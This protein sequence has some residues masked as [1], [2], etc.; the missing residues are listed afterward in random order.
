MYIINISYIYTWQNSTTWSHLVLLCTGLSSTCTYP[1]MMAPVRILIYH[2]L[3]YWCYLHV[4]CIH[5][6][7]EHNIGKECSTVFWPV[8]LVL[9][10]FFDASR[11]V[12]PEH[13]GSGTGCSAPKKDNCIRE[14]YSVEAS[15]RETRGACPQENTSSGDMRCFMQLGTYDVAF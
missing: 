10:A 6:S 4:L 8:R 13:P 3:M 9:L 2:I 7:K 12:T 1:R 5:I 11:I 14:R 15:E